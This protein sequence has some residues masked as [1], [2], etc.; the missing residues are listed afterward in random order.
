VV[1]YNPSP[2]AL[3][4]FRHGI[5][6]LTSCSYL[7]IVGPIWSI[8]VP[9]GA[10][11]TT[12]SGMADSLEHLRRIGVC[13]FSFFPTF[14]LWQTPTNYS[15]VRGGACVHHPSAS[16]MAALRALGGA[17]FKHQSVDGDRMGT[18]KTPHIGHVCSSF[19]SNFRPQSLITLTQEWH[20]PTIHV[21]FSN[22]N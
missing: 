17:K 22:S 4:K 15:Y 18:K 10:R 9:R 3:I 20:H 1:R 2:L 13:S 11:K 21:T 6:S 19:S 16:S 12:C 5:P 7:L 14:F 8:C